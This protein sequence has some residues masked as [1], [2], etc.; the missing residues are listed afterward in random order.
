M[1][2]PGSSLPVLDHREA[3]P[4][5]LLLP[6]PA[7]LSSSGWTDIH[8]EF[9]EQPKFSIA[10]HHHTLHAIAYG[11][12][13]SPEGCAA[14]DRWLDGKHCEEHR[15]PGN[16]A[17]IPAGIAHRCSWDQ[18]AQFMVLAIEPDL[19]SQ[20]GQDWV[21]PDHI[22]LVPQW[23]NRPDALI[24]GIF[25]T[26]KA[27]VEQGGLGGALLVDSLKTALVV[28]LL[29][30]YCATRPKL[31]GYAGGLSDLKL[32]QV[33]DY[34]QAHLHRDL[35]LVELAA[36]AQLSPYYFARLFKQSVGLTP[37]QYVLQCR[38]EQAQYLLRHT[39]LSLAEIGLRVGFCD[40]SHLSRCFKHRTG[41]TPTQFRQG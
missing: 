40:Q 6:Q 21:D 7:I 35:K 23:M 10:E 11:L 26:L 27:E 9:Y 31:S 3:N 12:A 36:I 38:I 8:F 15:Q 16:I 39:P 24:H 4:S 28:H 20:I 22:E 13:T 14:G 17:V 33:K 34:I 19:L 32:A 25:S 29:R 37:H 2:N 41:I 1:I 18:V 30:H 5:R